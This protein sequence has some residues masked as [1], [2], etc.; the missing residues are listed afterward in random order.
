M[1]QDEKEDIE[2]EVKQYYH[3]SGA[4]FVLIS[5]LCVSLA[6]NGKTT[7]LWIFYFNIISVFCGGFCMWIH[8]QKNPAWEGKFTYPSGTGSSEL[9]EE[10]RL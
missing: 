9:Q 10:G 7:G 5:L 2:S 8:T 4:W 1:P 6:A 3:L